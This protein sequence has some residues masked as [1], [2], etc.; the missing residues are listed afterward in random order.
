VLALTATASPPVREEIVERLHLRDAVQVVQ[1]FDR[2]GL[3][4]EVE[5][6][7]EEDQKRDA[8]VLRAMGEAKPGIVYTAT[9]KSAEAYAAALSELGIDAA[10]YHAGMRA[11]DREAAQARFMAGE[12]DVVVATTA[13]GMGIDKADVRFV[14]HAEVA[15]SLDSY[16]QEV[17]RAGRDGEPARAVLFYRE[18]DLGLRTF[19]ASGTADK[20]ALHKAA[21]LVQHAP[22]PVTPGE[23]AEE[24][25]L[26]KSR[27][28]G[29]V[30]LLEEAGGLEVTDDGAI[31]A[32]D[33]AG[34]AKELAQAAVE[35]SES[36]RRME[37][38][39][40]T[41]MRGFAETTG[42]RRQYLLAYFGESLDEPC[43]NCDTCEAGSAHA[44]PDPDASPFALGG[45][46]EHV[47][48][49]EGVVMRY[50]GDRIV[51]L[52]DEVGYRT[53][54]LQTVAARGLLREL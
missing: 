2:P 3:H 22:E 33:D 21:T 51:V 17:G 52:F 42:C 1:G 24:M 25:G 47:E 6:H 12:L 19:F 37:Q 8:V 18:A 11:A 39:R 49:G 28:V 40:L 29:L 16:Y 35:V 54:A 10:A 53:L 7:R 34:S 38:S 32:V 13:F 5:A 31:D 27:V 26:P 45:R 44:Q 50:E 36:H 9:R 20:P 15:D 30:N 14:L 4:L 48:W 41:M 43:G 46:V 23:L